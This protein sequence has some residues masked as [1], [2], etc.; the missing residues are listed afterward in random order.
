MGGMPRGGGG[1]G[2]GGTLGTVLIVVLLVVC[3]C[4]AAFQSL[5]ESDAFMVIVIAALVGVVGLIVYKLYDRRKDAEEE[6]TKATERM[7]KTP[8]EK[9]GDE[10]DEELDALEK[11]YDGAA[12]SPGTAGGGSVAFCPSCGAKILSD[13]QA[14]CA[15]CG[16]A[17]PKG[18]GGSSETA[19]QG[20][21]A[22]QSAD[23]STN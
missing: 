22:A 9:Y 7:L 23:S 2:C 14:F 17:L 11:K 6:E 4:A 19:S 5:F 18:G 16:A 20:D 8:L 12:R 13:G 21:S 10:T 15:S 3:L 1:S